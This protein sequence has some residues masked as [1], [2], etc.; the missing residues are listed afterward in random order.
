MRGYRGARARGCLCRAARCRRGAR[1]SACRSSKLLF[2][3]LRC[4]LVVLCC[5]FD[6]R[7]PALAP[8][9][10]DLADGLQ[11]EGR[12]VQTAD[13][14]L[15]EPVVWVGCVKQARATAG[16]EAATVV[17]RDLAAQLERLGGPV[18]EHREGAAGLL[19]ATRAVAA[20]D[21]QRVTAD[22]VTDRAAE[23]SAGAYACLHA[24]RCY[25]NALLLLSILARAPLP[26][27]HRVKT[28]R[29]PLA[30]EPVRLDQARL[31]AEAQAVEQTANRNVAIVGLG[32]D[33]VHAA[34]LEQF[35]H[36]SRQ[37]FG[38][39]A[40]ALACLRQRDPDLGGRRLVGRDS[41]SAIS[42]QCALLPIHDG[43]LQPLSGST[44]D[45]VAL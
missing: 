22:A 32:E 8:F 21:V 16:A 37:R 17:A 26:V 18:R 33:S 35:C 31:A 9:N 6:R 43:Q 2:V 44:E 29:R 20:P 30:L 24:R 36:D 1:P 34:L 25:A 7:Y 38:C 10:P 13:P 14:N 41:H 15:D 42:T 12:L 23:T 5:A 4:A 11:L 40:L 19:S 39:Q 27:Q 3:V 45:Q 28:Q